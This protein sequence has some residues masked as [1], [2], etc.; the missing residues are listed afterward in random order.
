MSQQVV[1]KLKEVRP[2][3]QACVALLTAQSCWQQVVGR[4]SHRHPNVFDNPH[5]SMPGKSLH[6]L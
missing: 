4:G 6:V 2:A 1:A 3:L 5:C